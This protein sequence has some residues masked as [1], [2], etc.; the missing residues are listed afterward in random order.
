MAKKR[1]R[2]KTSLITKAINVGVLLLAF[3]RPIEL[4]LARGG[5]GAG[6]VIARE[7]SFGMSDGGNFNLNQGLQMYGPMIGALVL[8]KV[9]SMV[10]KTAHF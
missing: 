3:K 4:F 6:E 9:I 1:R 7:A 5:V 2:R 10:R 8:K